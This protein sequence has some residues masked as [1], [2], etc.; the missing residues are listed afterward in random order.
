MI[1][2]L[3]ERFLFKGFKEDMYADGITP[4]E[5]VLFFK[6]LSRID[7]ID[8]ILKSIIKRDRVAYFNASNNEE[9]EKVRGAFYRVLWLLREIRN[10]RKIEEKS[11]EEY[12][13]PRHA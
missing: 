2:N 1:R 10:Q 8:E 5:L 13:S 4:E 9:R 7:K 11:K 6:D 3:L 12:T